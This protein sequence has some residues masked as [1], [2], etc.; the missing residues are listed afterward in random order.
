MIIYLNDANICRNGQQL[1]TQDIQHK[2]DEIAAAGGGELIIPPGRYLCSALSLPSNLIL[3]FQPGAVLVA[4]QSIFDYYHIKTQSMAELSYRA[5]LYAVNQRNI[6]I[7][8]T[9]EIDGQGEFWFARDADITG[10]RNP[11]QERPRL[12]VM[13]NCTDICLRDFSVR[14]S[15]MWTLHLACCQNITIDN[16]KVDNHLAL[17]NTDCL[18]LD[19]CQYV[20]ISNC[21]FSA[22]DDGICIKTTQKSFGHLQ[23]S[24]HITITN[25]VIRS[26]GAAIKVGTESFADV[27]HLLVNNVSV[28]DS[29]RAVALVSRDGGHLRHMTFSQIRYQC[30]LCSAHHWGKSEPVHISVRYRSPHITPG[31]IE[32]ITFSQFDGAAQGAFCLYSDIT[33]AIAHITFD[34]VYLQQTSSAHPDWGFYDVRPPCNPDNP[35][36]MGLDNSYKL[37]PHTG[38]PFGVDPYEGGVP[39]FYVRGVKDLAVRHFTRILDDSTNPLWNSNDIVHLPV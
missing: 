8:G 14:Y 4:S 25:C 35:T 28:Y 37:N 39:G 32:D 26:R 27:E 16:I 7:C 3:N 5:L 17:P 23:M 30:H 13:E 10:Y 2:L 38:R 33:D 6:T 24:A 12:L 11:A 20:R 18:D 29:N 15:P 22:A 31:K 1:V 19:S 34:G 36:G 9:G 21:H